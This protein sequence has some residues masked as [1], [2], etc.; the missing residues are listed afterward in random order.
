LGFCLPK[1]Y[2]Q[3]RHKTT[4]AVG[5]NEQHG[6]A[7]G[8]Q[9]RGMTL[10]A[11]ASEVEMPAS[12]RRSATPWCR[13]LSW[14]FPVIQ[15]LHAHDLLHSKDYAF[16][17]IA[18]GDLNGDGVPDVVLTGSGPGYG[19]LILTKPD[20]RPQRGPSERSLRSHP[21]VCTERST[22]PCRPTSTGMV[23]STS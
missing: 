8:L 12:A 5:L 11:V 13:A 9:E 14:P 7:V 22:T 18:C 4:A 19:I 2:E 20:T 6:R 21:G 16:K 10:R 1:R 15:S 3:I 17:G 23:I